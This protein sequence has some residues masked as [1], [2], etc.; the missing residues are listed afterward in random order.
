MRELFV[1]ILADDGRAASSLCFADLPVVRTMFKLW[2]QIAND[3]YS[4]LFHPCGPRLASSK[5]HLFNRAC[6]HLII[7]KAGC[8][9]ETCTVGAGLITAACHAIVRWGR[10]QPRAGAV[11][12][13]DMAGQTSIR[14]GRSGMSPSRIAVCPLI[15]LADHI[16]NFA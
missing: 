14:W 11:R 8:S 15:K 13:R 6:H 12:S 7:L 9:A 16:R 1:K 3:H 4:G 10:D 2:R 5:L